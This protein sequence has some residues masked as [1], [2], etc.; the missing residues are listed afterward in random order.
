MNDLDNDLCARDEF[1]GLLLWLTDPERENFRA[2]LKVKYGG[3]AK[4]A[5]KSMLLAYRLANPTDPIF[6]K[7]PLALKLR[8]EK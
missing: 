1:R 3:D 2:F 8:E 4:E 5:A 6:D 7:D